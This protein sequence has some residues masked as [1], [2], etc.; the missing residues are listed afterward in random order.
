[1]KLEASTA[2]GSIIARFKGL[3]G[4][5]IG[6]SVI[7]DQSGSPAHQSFS[8][9]KSVILAKRVSFN[10]PRSSLNKERR[11]SRAEFESSFNSVVLHSSVLLLY[12]PS[13]FSA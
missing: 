9:M 2:S 5:G 10:L 4:S 1:M 13:S 6:T 8:K 3:L 12:T 11:E 7:D